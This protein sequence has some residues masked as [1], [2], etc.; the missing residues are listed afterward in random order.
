MRLTF[1]QQCAK[2]SNFLPHIRRR[3]SQNLEF[4]FLCSILDSYFRPSH[5]GRGL[6]LIFSLHTPSARAS[7]YVHIM[8]ATYVHE[9]LDEAHIRLITLIP[10]QDTIQISIGQA[11]FST[12]TFPR[13]EALSYTWGDPTKLVD[14]V[15]VISERTTVKRKNLLSKIRKSRRQL[16][17]SLSAPVIFHVT[18]NLY[19]ALLHLRGN[20]PRVLWIDAICLYL[21][22]CRTKYRGNLRLRPLFS[23]GFR[24][25]L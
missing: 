10:G 6:A 7:R 18:E 17:P 1:G 3:R 12:I 16:Q 19:S 14:S 4:L 2:V 24:F 21:D 13:Y 25:A 11:P 5:R 15:E 8:S 9:P 20:E 22:R 23:E